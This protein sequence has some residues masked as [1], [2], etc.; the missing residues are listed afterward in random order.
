[1]VL[2]LGARHGQ[3]VTLWHLAMLARNAGKLSAAGALLEQALGVARELEDRRGQARLLLELGQVR[4]DEGDLELA[5]DLLAAA[6]AVW[7][8][9]TEHHSFR[10][11]TL[12]GLGRLRRRQQRYDQAADYFAEAA[13]QWGQ[14]RAQTARARSLEAL[15]D[16][17]AAAGR[18]QEAA[19]A[20]QQALESHRRAG[21][22]GESR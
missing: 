20:R 4:T 22:P 1:L 16:A 14:L 18:S 8:T 19:T 13:S 15:G 7:P 5:D 11:E 3:A 6:Q 9:Y 21:S 10:A 2:L 12:D 17:F